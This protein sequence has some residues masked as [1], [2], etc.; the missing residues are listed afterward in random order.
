MSATKAATKTDK[1]TIEM[2]YPQ[3]NIRKVTL[4]VTWGSLALTA[5][6]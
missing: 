5:R 6:N 4:K 2:S 1:L 3:N